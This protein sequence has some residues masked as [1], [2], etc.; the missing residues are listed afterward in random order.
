M[1][2]VLSVLQSIMHLNNCI[3]NTQHRPII[4]KNKCISLNSCEWKLIFVY[5]Y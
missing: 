2:H 3:L 1:L 5:I 4:W